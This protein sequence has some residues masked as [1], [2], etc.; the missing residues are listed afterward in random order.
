[1]IVLEFREVHY[2]TFFFFFAKD[3]YLLVPVAGDIVVN[4]KGIEP[5]ISELGIQHH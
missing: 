5:A 4:E 1:M 2:M 3:L